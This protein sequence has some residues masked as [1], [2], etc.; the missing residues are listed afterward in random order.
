MLND[1]QQKFNYSIGVREKTDVKTLKKMIP[2]CVKVKTTTREQD[3]RGIDFEVVLRGGAKINIDM[4]TREPGCSKW[5]RDRS[6]PELAQEIWSLTPNKAL[7][8]HGKENKKSDKEKVGWSLD[9]GKETHL[10]LYTFD[11]ADTSACF[12]LS[13]HHCRMALRKNWKAWNF[14]FPATLQL[15]KNYYSECLF[16]PADIL[17]SAIT[18]VSQG[19][20]IYDQ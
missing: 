3:K 1:F 7:K 16:I 13:F 19:I 12:L 20:Y 10:I 6:E 9:E 17:T 11:I 5:W 4:K 8:K 14:M 18:D 2:G 15:N